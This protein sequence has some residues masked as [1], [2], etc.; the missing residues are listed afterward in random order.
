MYLYMKGGFDYLSKRSKQKKK[1]TTKTRRTRSRSNRKSTSNRRS[2]TNTGR[3]K[4]GGN[5]NALP[6]HNYYGYNSNVLTNPVSTGG[7]KRKSRK[8]KRVKGGNAVLGDLATG[9]GQNI[10]TSFG[11]TMGTSTQ[12][13]V[14]TSSSNVSSNPAIQPN[15][16][17]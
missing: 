9:N 11:N 8:N 10:I 13:N 14:L 17:T 16:L 6:L 15:L 7:K 2:R 4:Y 3:V 5:L 1:S 12:Y